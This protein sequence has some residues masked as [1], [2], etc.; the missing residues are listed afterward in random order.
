M[1]YP[2]IGIGSLKIDQTCSSATMHIGNDTSI[3]VTEDMN[4]LSIILIRMVKAYNLAT[5][6]AKL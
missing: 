3:L 1:E 2:H 5:I 6:N 4:R